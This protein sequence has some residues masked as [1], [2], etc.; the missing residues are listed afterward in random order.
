MAALLLAQA[1][2]GAIAREPSGGETRQA[3]IDAE[4]DA[5]VARFELPGLAVGMVEGGKV[6]YVRTVGELRVGGGEPVTPA[7][8]FKIASNSKAMTTALLA[9]LVDQGKL[10][11]DDPV[12]K[13]LP[14]FRMHD[15]WVTREIQVRDL[16]I[17]NSGLGAGAGDLM[18]WPEPNLFTREDVIAGMAHLK[19]IYSFRSRYAYDNTL[20]I[21]AGEVAAAAAGAESYEALLRSELFEPLGLE[22]CRVG[23]WRRD[24]VGNIAQPH[25]RIDGR[26]VPVRED[27]DT[28]AAVPMAAAGGIRCSLDDMLR[29]ITMWLQPERSGLID[30]APWL[31][32]EQR[33]ALWTAHTPMPLGRRLREWDGAHFHAYG[34]GW[35]LNDADGRLKVSHTGTLSGM[36]SA[37]TLLPELGVGFVVLMNGGGSDARSALVQALSKRFTAPEATG[38]TVDD[39][40]DAI[41]AEA[42]A[43]RK[44]GSTSAPDTSSRQAADIDSMTPW[45]GVYRD[46]WFGEAS[47]CRRGD[48]VR[49]AA[50]RSP[51]LSGTV[52]RVGERRLVDW[53]EV[54][55]DAE[56]WLAFADADTADAPPTLT[57]SKVDPQADFSYDYED[58]AFVRVGDCP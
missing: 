41:A 31:S 2:Q 19:P 26:N 48:V 9:R 16:L 50:A 57:M 23:E 10:A 28:V 27:G 44:D 4:V 45:L 38:R 22:R 42:A 35:R 40:A 39:Y 7:T 37:V 21:V 24:E 25:L 52:M 30:G 43:D 56:A 11:W 17:H 51:M 53:D 33:E 54:S 15:P 32:E 36:Y 58:L 14:D 12:I 55:V 6:T 18:L 34:Y 5:A 20:Y 46:P 29:W 3:A 13:H 47:V 1:M 49:F 8:L